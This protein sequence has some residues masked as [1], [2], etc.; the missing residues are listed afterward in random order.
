MTQLSRGVLGLALGLMLAIPVSAETLTVYTAVEA[1]D[2]K[3][4]KSEFNKDH[5]D[6]DIRWVRDSTG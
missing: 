5:P 2:L 6:I 1:E 4:Y 3:R